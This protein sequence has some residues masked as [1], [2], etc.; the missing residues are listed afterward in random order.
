MYNRIWSTEITVLSNIQR[1][2]A[3]PSGPGTLPATCSE[4]ATELATKLAAE[5]AAKPFEITNAENVEQKTK[6]WS[7]TKISVQATIFWQAATS[8]S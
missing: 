6:V 1:T 7:D 3:K 5:L 8:T 4:P 2:D